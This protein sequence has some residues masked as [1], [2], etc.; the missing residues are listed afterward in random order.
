MSQQAHKSGNATS[1]DNKGSDN[2][3]QSLNNSS[4][5]NQILIMQ[6]PTDNS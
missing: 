4:L 2:V 1:I 5:N 3:I 6:L